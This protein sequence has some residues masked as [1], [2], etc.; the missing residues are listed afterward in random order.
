MKQTT[1]LSV[2]MRGR[3]LGRTRR[4]CHCDARII[5][6]AQKVTAAVEP[7]VKFFPRTRSNGGYALHRSRHLAIQLDDCFSQLIEAVFQPHASCGASSHRG[8]NSC[9]QLS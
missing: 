1:E 6:G 9:Q 3:K 8:M 4:S 7:P 2:E 5:T